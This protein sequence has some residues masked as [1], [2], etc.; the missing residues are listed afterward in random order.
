MPAGWHP[1]PI[2][3]LFSAIPIGAML[4]QFILIKTAVRTVAA[5][6]A[7]LVLSCTSIS[8]AEVSSCS[9]SPPAPPD[10]APEPSRSQS[11]GHTRR[12]AGLLLKTLSV[13]THP[14]DA[15]ASA[16]SEE[17][18]RLP[19]ETPPLPRHA[20]SGLSPQNPSPHSHRLTARHGDIHRATGH[21]CPAV[22]VPPAI[23]TFRVPAVPV[24]LRSSRCPRSVPGS[25]CHPPSRTCIP[26]QHG[27]AQTNTQ[28]AGTIVTTPPPSCEAVSST[29]LVSPVRPKM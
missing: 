15:D 3:A 1:H 23:S 6:V 19:R 14:P 11:A 28:G 22:R 17:A 18:V 7:L 10:N 20:D 21:R 12:P 5:E 25:G 29:V 13:N 8:V 16:P 24:R 27:V 2:P 9:G 4:H 26:F